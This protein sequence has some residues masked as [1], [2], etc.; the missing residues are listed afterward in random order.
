MLGILWLASAAV[1]LIPGF[2]LMNFFYPG[3]GL[4]PPDV[5]PFLSALMHGIGVFVIGGAVLGLIAGW[6][7][8]ERQPW[9]RTSLLAASILVRSPRKSKLQNAGR[10][11][12]KPVGP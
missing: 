11:P 7:L 5:P 6:G 3:A 8:L 4:L 10:P 12:A 2:F 1:H 9:A